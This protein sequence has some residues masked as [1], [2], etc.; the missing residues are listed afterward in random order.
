MSRGWIGTAMV[1]GVLVGVFGVTSAN[2]DGEAGIVI[3]DG[4]AVRTY[5]I[6]FQG[7]GIRGD[8][9]LRAA[10][11]DFDAY[12]GGSGLAV[13]S[14]GERG[15]QDASS[16]SS[17]FCECQGG[18]CEYWAFFTRSYGNSWA[19]SSLAFNLLQVKDGDVHGWK[20]GKGAPSSAPSPKD[21]TFDKICGH[22]PRGG[23]AP[24]ATTAQPTATTQAPPPVGTLLPASPSA[25]APSTA[26]GAAAGPGTSTPLV[27]LP[28]QSPTTSTAAATPGVPASG[29]EDGEEPNGAGSLVAFGVVGAFLLA[30]IGGGLV[31]RKRHAG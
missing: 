3:Q 16:F 31:W 30:A 4:D 27:T 11:Q 17:C 13:C 20:W 26:T 7:D 24:T 14:I 6:P 12:G 19:Y 22:G 18:D 28:S 25:A 21:V 15:C 8:V 9:L 2:A 23:V 1:L 5:C 10:G 29:S